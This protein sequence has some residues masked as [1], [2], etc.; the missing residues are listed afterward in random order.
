MKVEEEYSPLVTR[1]E[2]PQ[3]RTLASRRFAR[4]GG[5]APSGGLVGAGVRGPER[6]GLEGFPLRIFQEGVCHAGTS[7]VPTG[8]PGLTLPRGGEGI[9]V[10]AC[11]FL[12]NKKINPDC[13]PRRRERVAVFA[14]LGPGF[15]AARVRPAPGAGLSKGQEVCAGT[16]PG[17]G[18]AR[19]VPEPAGSPTEPWAGTGAGAGPG[20]RASP[21]L[22]PHPFPPD[23]RGGRSREGLR[24]AGPSW[25][26][27]SSPKAGYAS[28]LRASPGARGVP[29]PPGWAPWG[30][31]TEDKAAASGGAPAGTAGRLRASL[32]LAP[33]R[34]SAG[35]PQD[36]RAGR[37][38]CC[39]GLPPGER[40]REKGVG[41]SA[42]LDAVGWSGRWLGEVCM[43]LP[44]R[45]RSYLELY[46]QESGDQA[47]AESSWEQGMKSG[48]PSLG[49]NGKEYIFAV[50]GMVL[51]V[52]SNP[53]SF[54]KKENSSA[55]FF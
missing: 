30:C 5:S 38:R 16:T 26:A 22:V 27:E 25:M 50:F 32:H 53:A 11:D 39:A 35:V 7:E 45:T 28:D 21:P 17:P 36:A 55:F 13:T 44:L 29:A 31:E 46:Q 54:C 40:R 20:A 43:R 24:G 3:R 51:K 42:G 33:S 48:S 23:G 9:G 37:T 1:T 49:V 10:S 52:T 47:G 12:P 41:A 6:I 2:R 15:S 14:V 34:S 19:S 4:S 18:G 8:H